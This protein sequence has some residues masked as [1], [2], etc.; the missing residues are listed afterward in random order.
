ITG[1]PYTICNGGSIAITTGVTG[2]GPFLYSW[3][4]AG[5]NSTTVASPTA[6]PT[7]TTN[8]VVTVLDGN[9][10]QATDN[11]DVNVNPVPTLTSATGAPVCE[12]STA[13]ITLNGLLASSTSTVAFS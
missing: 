1:T 7:T 3:T 2:D 9:G 10:I 8:Y 4:G 11:E 13:T 12:G 6:S 5:L